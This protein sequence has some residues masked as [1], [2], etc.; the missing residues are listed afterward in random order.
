MLLLYKSGKNNRALGSQFVIAFISI[1][2]FVIIS[3]VFSSYALTKAALL[4]TDISI[5]DY[6]AFCSWVIMSIGG[7]TYLYYCLR[8]RTFTRYNFFILFQATTNLGLIVFSTYFQFKSLT[9]FLLIQCMIWL[10]L[11]IIYIF[12]LIKNLSFTAS[13]DIIN[14]F[15]GGLYFYFSS[16]MAATHLNF[17]RLYATY[18]LTKEDVAEIGFLFIFGALLM[19]V[20]AAINVVFLPQAKEGYKISDRFNLIKTFIVFLIVIHLL[21][22]FL[23]NF[24]VTTFLAETYYQLGPLLVNLIPAFLFYNVAIILSTQLNL[25]GNYK[26]MLAASVIALTIQILVSILFSPSYQAIFYSYYCYSITYFAIIGFVFYIRL[27]NE[28]FL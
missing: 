13:K 9:T 18:Y 22:A 5:V 7:T 23:G 20:P 6:V 3:F 25:I 2:I 26:A 10:P 12:A 17:P 28:A 21:F 1:V 27:R 24:L 14:L 16:I 8:D 15:Q 11:F 19:K 4:G